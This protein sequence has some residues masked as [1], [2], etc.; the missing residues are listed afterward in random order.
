MAKALLGHVGGI[1]SVESRDNARL[2]NRVA[3]L[4]DEVGRLRRENDLLHSELAAHLDAEH[5]HPERLLE[6]VSH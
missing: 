2:R 5:L 4:Q 6:P 3:E 1:D